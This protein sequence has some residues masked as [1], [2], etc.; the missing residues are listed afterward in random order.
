MLQVSSRQRHTRRGS[1]SVYVAIMLTMLMAILALAIDGGQLYDDL[2]K[3]QNAAD[4]ASLAAAV[5]MN[6]DWKTGGAGALSTAA[7]TTARTQAAA[8]GYT[9]GTGGVV[10]SV[11]QPTT[12]LP[13]GYTP[14]N[15]PGYVDVT[16]TYPQKLFFAGVWGNKNMTGS[17]TSRARGG[18]FTPAGPAAIIILSK[19]ELNGAAQMDEG[20][21]EVTV[22]D[23]SA[24]QVGSTASNGLSLGP[25]GKMK[26]G[27]LELGSSSWT[28]GSLSNV[29]STILYN[30]SIQDPYATL[31]PPSAAT[32]TKTTPL[33]NS[34]KV[35]SGNT[36]LSPG[37][38]TSIEASGN[39]SISF[40]P[41]VYIITGANNGTG[42]KLSG[43]GVSVD[44]S[45][46]ASPDT[47]NG[48]L[49]YFTGGGLDVSG[50]GAFN[51]PAPDSGTFGP[52]WSG[53]P[54]SFWIDK[55]NPDAN[56]TVTNQPG[57]KISGNGSYQVNGVVYG[58]TTK[59]KVNGNGDSLGMQLVVD[60]LVLDGNNSK[61]K[62]GNTGPA[63]AAQSLLNLIR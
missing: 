9:N 3:A 37:V 2:R 33:D 28:G 29:P 27:R 51:L 1:V 17:A 55:N 54:M 14:S 56:N 61:V 19:K 30:Q 38:Y 12:G 50:N 39:G 6:T 48:V 20:N 41:G 26:G 7:I 43:N 63:P 44:T 8:Y 32:I 52:S 58:P 53:N 23:D 46:G 34:P 35:T 62:F 49:F 5:Q 24:V 59:A 11:T 36:L 13:A 15:G 18:W 47:G 25:N 16:I 4:A 45:G 40:K 22:P 31:T 21:G 60:Q 42:L 57:I 10:V